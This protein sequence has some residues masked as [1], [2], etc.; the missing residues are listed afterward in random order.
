M[1]CRNWCGATGP[2]LR[3]P[4]YPA[5]FSF[6][7][8]H[9]LSMCNILYLDMPFAL[10]CLQNNEGSIRVESFA[11][12]TVYH[13]PE[14]CLAHSRSSINIRSMFYKEYIG[15]RNC[16]GGRYWRGPGKDFLKIREGGKIMELVNYLL[17][18]LKLL[19]N[20]PPNKISKTCGLSS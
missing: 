5:F 15:K 2:Y 18:P 13:T 16:N 7:H 11:L 14:E 4:P 8:T 3:I 10:Y 1:C 20:T 9:H 17:R 6:S 12:F 19:S